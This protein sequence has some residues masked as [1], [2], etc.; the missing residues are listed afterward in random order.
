MKTNWNID[1]E[2]KIISSKDLD[3]SFEFEIE[4]EFRKWHLRSKEIVFK[5]EDEKEKANKLFKS[6]QTEFKVLK[7]IETL[8][9]DGF[10][11][12]NYMKMFHLED[13]IYVSE[14]GEI[15][16]LEADGFYETSFRTSAFPISEETSKNLVMMTIYNDDEIVKYK[17]FEI[18]DSEETINDIPY[19]YNIEDDF[20]EIKVNDS[21]IRA[22]DDYIIKKDVNDKDK[23]LLEALVYV[24]IYG[25]KNFLT[26]N[27][28]K[29][30]L[31]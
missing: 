17:D 21:V 28:V 25:N 30:E 9:F 23:E 19:M 14:D 27:E 2:N 22:Y 26:W 31:N 16:T 29:T 24:L 12:W 18:D 20:E 10:G 6:L 5:S 13:N 8:K 1:I 4:F 7:Y 15:C 11:D 3:F